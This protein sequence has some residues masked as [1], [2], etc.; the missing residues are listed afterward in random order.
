MIMLS[1]INDSK[2]NTAKRKHYRERHILRKNNMDDFP[3]ILIREGKSGILKALAEQF[4]EEVT[5]V[6]CSF[7]IS[8]I[9]L[10]EKKCGEKKLGLIEW[11]LHRCIS[12]FVSS[13]IKCIAVALV[14]FTGLPS[15]AI[16]WI[17]IILSA[18]VKTLMKYRLD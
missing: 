9:S 5:G 7:I 16:I 6:E 12:L 8:I 11:L 15:E 2:E 14:I 4:M 17:S 10:R 3:E 1:K 18:G 13:V